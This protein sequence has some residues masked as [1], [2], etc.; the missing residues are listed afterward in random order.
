MVK[1]PL[2]INY[3][4]KETLKN[5]LPSLEYCS[6][7]Y[8]TWL[9]YRNNPQYIWYNKNIGILNTYFDV[10]REFQ[11]ILHVIKD[12]I[13][14]AHKDLYNLIEYYA[15]KSAGKINQNRVFAKGLAVMNQK[16]HLDKE[17]TDLLGELSGCRNKIAHDVNYTLSYALNNRQ[18]IHNL[19][20][21]FL[22]LI[23][24]EC[25]P[26]EMKMFDFDERYT[27][28]QQQFVNEIGMCLNDL[29]Y[30]ASNNYMCK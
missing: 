5:F 16:N 25:N 13:L 24:N 12:I 27:R 8:N 19:L 7:R 2:E 29:E 18:N 9:F 6:H 17:K 20:V 4:I 11:D 23:E 30:Y 21:Y 1:S 15:F 14:D 26:F 22:G 3:K 28:M 10:D